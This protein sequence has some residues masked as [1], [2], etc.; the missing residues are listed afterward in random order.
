VPRPSI[1]FRRIDR[2][3]RRA[4]GA[5]RVREQLETRSPM[6]SPIIEGQ[7]MKLSIPRDLRGKRAS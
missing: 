6:A 2:N 1:V 7:P 5:E 3:Q 4:V